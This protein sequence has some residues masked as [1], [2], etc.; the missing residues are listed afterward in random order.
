MKA[1]KF[2][3]THDLKNTLNLTQK[4]YLI[5]CFFFYVFFI[6]FYIKETKLS[7]F[8]LCHQYILC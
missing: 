2:M 5:K 6:F 3:V 4:N 7:L 1:L 8:R